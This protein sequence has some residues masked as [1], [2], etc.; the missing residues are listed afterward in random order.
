MAIRISMRRRLLTSVVLFVLGVLMVSSLLTNF[1]DSDMYGGPVT[2]GEDYYYSWGTWNVVNATPSEPPLVAPPA[3]F[4]SGE[5]QAIN[6]GLIMINATNNTK[7]LNNFKGCAESI[8]R[9]STQLPVHFVLL[10]DNISVPLIREV[11]RNLA[12]IRAKVPVTV[13]YLNLEESTRNHSSVIDRLQP[14]FSPTDPNSK[15]N[16][17]LFHIAPIYH[18]LLSPATTRLLVID[19]DVRF[20]ADVADLYLQ[21]LTFQP[22]EMMALAAEL[23]PMYDKPFERYRKLNGKSKD[24]L[25]KPQG[26]FP[27]F[28]SGV[29]LYHLG[30][31]RSNGEYNALLDQK[32]AIENLCNKF[33]NYRGAA[34]GDQD[35]LTLLKVHRPQWVREI[36]CGWNYQLDMTMAVHPFFGQYH[37]CDSEAKILHGNGGAVIPTESAFASL[38]SSIASLEKA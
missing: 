23:S 3:P 32:S 12:R 22:Q 29:V 16:K 31:M 15:Y 19:A 27:G 18:R 26:G 8:L 14:L 10:T 36:D 4:G 11:I 33:G 17:R 24:G 37:L 1:V 2:T 13:D 30:H 5:V 9:H 6:I 7:L 28:N 25:P 35:F 34:V 21:L 20:R 38:T